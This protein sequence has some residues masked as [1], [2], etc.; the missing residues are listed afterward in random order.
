MEPATTTPPNFKAASRVLEI[1]E[2]HEMILYELPPLDLL[3]SQRVSRSWQNTISKS[4]KLQ[5]ALFFQPAE[6]GSVVLMERGTCSDFSCY[7][8]TY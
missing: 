4:K 3:I 6:G 1:A 5:Q 7:Y 8:G 2:L